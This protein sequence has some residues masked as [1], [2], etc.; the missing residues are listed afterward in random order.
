[1]STYC[2]DHYADKAP[3]GEFETYTHN[4]PPGSIVNCLRAG[5]E[6]LPEKPES[7]MLDVGCAVGR[8]SFELAAHNP[9][10]T[11]G[12]DLNFSLLRLAQHVLRERKIVFP[13][14]RIG[15]VY[16]RHNYEVVLDHADHVDFWACDALALPFV[17][18]T[19]GFVSALNVFDV[20][21]APRGLLVAIRN[22][23]K[24]GGSAVIGTPYDYSPPVPVPNWVGGHSQRNPEQ[25]AGE[26]ALRAMFSQADP[27]AV[28]GLNMIGEIEHQNWMM[29]I[30]SRRTVH[31]DSHIVAFKKA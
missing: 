6:L 22:K 11:L 19:F 2:W 12:I 17:N 30:H 3:Q 26:P 4:A 23:L 29:R 13:L 27:R 5:L 15:L 18:D 8:S 10:M 16:E 7:P 24:S 1:M 14:K 9:G 25:G 21:S 31:Y 20:V 28:N